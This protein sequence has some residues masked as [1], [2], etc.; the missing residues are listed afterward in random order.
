MTQKL[1]NQKECFT[2]FTFKKEII[3]I[4]KFDT[5]LEWRCQ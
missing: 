4:K 2:V 5:F 1:E 3:T